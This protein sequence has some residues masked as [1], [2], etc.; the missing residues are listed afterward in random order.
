MHLPTRKKLK[1]GIEVE[2]DW[3]HPPDGQQV[4]GLFN[5]VIVEGETYSQDKP[6]SDEE[7]TA[8]WLNRDAFVVRAVEDTNIQQ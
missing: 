4:R 1:N 5:T 2:I 3:M 6:L 8:Y 7:F